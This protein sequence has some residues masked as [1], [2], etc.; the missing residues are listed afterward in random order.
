MYIRSPRG[1]QALVH[2]GLPPGT[3]AISQLHTHICIYRVHIIYRHPYFYIYVCICIYTY[4]CICI[5][6]GYT[7]ACLGSKGRSVNRRVTYLDEITHTEFVLNDPFRLYVPAVRL[8][9]LPRCVV[10][11]FPPCR[12][13]P[14][15]A[16]CC[17]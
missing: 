4:I 9:V 17:G 14:L 10:Q 12:C 8:R 1:E 15:R 7:A 11:W 13:E 3:Y 5:W 2:R 16:G 6:L